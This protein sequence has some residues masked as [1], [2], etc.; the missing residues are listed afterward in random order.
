[1]PQTA[2]NAL[3]NHRLIL[4]RRPDTLTDP[5]ADDVLRYETSDVPEPAEGQFLVR[6]HW[7]SLDPATRGWMNDNRNY[8]VPTEIGEVM[9]ALSAGEVIASKHPRY[10]VGALVEGLLGAQEYAISDGKSSDGKEIRIIPSTIPLAAS[11]NVL[12]I[13]GLTAWFGIHDIGTPKAGET[14]VV[15]AAAGG[16]GS[17]AV[18]LLKAAGCRVIGLAGDQ[19]KCDWVRSL[20]AVE[21]INYKT[22]DV[23]TAIARL[24]PDRIDI[25]FDN[26]GGSMLDSLLPSLAF[27]SRVILCGAISRYKG[28]PESLKNWFPLLINRTRMQGFIYRDHEDRFHEAEADLLPRLERHEIQYREHVID[29]LEKAPQALA[30]LFDGSN[31]GKLLVKIADDAK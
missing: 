22:D 20:G 15:T 30:M 3:H 26:V 27:H 8:I 18:Q 25:V 10:P 9:R 6:I 29:G 7:M 2:V 11:L 28:Q 31:R 1:M 14:A 16:V 23:T 5:I 4:A 21:C 12:G 17:V 13:N 24:C 19:E